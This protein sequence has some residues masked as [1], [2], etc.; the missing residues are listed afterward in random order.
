MHVGL[1]D[2]RVQGLVDAPPRF[3]DAREEAAF[4]ELGDAELDV[5]GL[6]RD[7]LRPVPV[8]LGSPRLGAFIEA[9]ADLGRGLGFYELLANKTDSLSDEVN[10]FTALQRVSELGQD[11]LIKGLRVISSVVRSARNTLR[12]SPMAPPSGGPCRSAQS[13]PLEGHLPAMM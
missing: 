10:D 3:Q 1:H 8:A 6:G 4:A 7:G 2:H 11:R 5:A 9:R 12:F 13:P